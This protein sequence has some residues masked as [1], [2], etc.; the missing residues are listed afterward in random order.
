MSNVPRRK[1]TLTMARARADSERFTLIPM[2][3]AAHS[4]FLEVSTSVA[5]ILGAEALPG[6]VAAEQT[7]LVWDGHTRTYAE[8]RDRALRLATALRARGLDTGDRVAAHLLNRGEIFEVYFAC[9]Y[10]GLTL[11]PIS[12]RLMAREI[13]QILSDCTPILVVS[14]PSVAAQIR[15]PAGER[16]IE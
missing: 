10:A 1:P 11:V 5:R 6:H 14:E 12:W 16:A 3:A 13:D 2:I 9:A 4:K 8:L 15:E 7:A